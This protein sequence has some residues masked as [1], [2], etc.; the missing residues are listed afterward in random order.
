VE[1]ERKETNMLPN[2][3]KK[4]VYSLIQGE[5]GAV[6]ASGMYP[7]W[8]LTSPGKFSHFVNRHRSFQKKKVKQKLPEDVTADSPSKH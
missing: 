5:E 1:L 3:Q 6:L 4:I 7:G 8:N 2:E